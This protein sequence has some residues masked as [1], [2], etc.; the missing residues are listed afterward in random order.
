LFGT[1]RNVTTTEHDIR[2]AEWPQDTPPLRIAFA[3]DFHA[4]P[5]TH[6]D[7]WAA[8][9]DA[10]NRAEPDILLLGGDFVV[11]EARHVDALAAR[12]GQV[13][14]PLGCY[15]VLGNH[16]Y[17]AGAEYITRR[18]EAAGIRMLTNQGIR[19]PAPHAHVWI[20]GLDDWGYGEP[21]AA[22]ALDGA[23]GIR[24]VLMHNPLACW[25]SGRSSSTWRSAGMCTV[26]RSHCRVDTPS[27]YPTDHSRAGT[28]AG[29][30]R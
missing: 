4:G 1:P 14:A 22:A 25:T 11:L 7:L 24:I 9:C 5:T 3:S 12:L 18:L 26:G 20:C 15:A 13:A 27:W 29:A 10:L 6:P 23:E 8:A 28:P 17:Y 16:D 2:L 30:F 19:L 21:D